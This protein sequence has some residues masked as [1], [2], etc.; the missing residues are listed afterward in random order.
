MSSVWSGF[1]STKS[2]L[3]MGSYTSDGGCQKN[4]ET[5]SCPINQVFPTSKEWERTHKASAYEIIIIISNKN[6]INNHLTDRQHLLDLIIL[7]SLK[8]IKQKAN[9][10]RKKKKEHMAEVFQDLWLPTGL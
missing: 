4:E 8:K 5:I 2:F 6:N 7:R 3:K 10:K 9:N 1:C